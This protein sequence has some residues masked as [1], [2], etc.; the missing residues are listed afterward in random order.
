MSALGDT[1]QPI[2]L[3]DYI[4]AKRHGGLIY[5]A[6]MTPRSNGKMQAFGPV[7]PGEVA[8]HESAVVLSC[9]NALRAAKAVLAEDEEIAEVLTMTVYVAGAEGFSEHSTVAD[10][11]SAYLREQLGA[12]GICSRCAIGVANLPGNAPVEIQLILA[13]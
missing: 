8:C 2:P 13:V 11:G 3:G 6:G 9:A 10:F 1:P 4:A 5:T 12:R 7:R